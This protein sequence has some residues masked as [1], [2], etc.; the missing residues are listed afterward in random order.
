MK[1]SD[2]LATKIKALY[3]SGV[4][5]KVLAI[6]FDIPIGSIQTLINRKPCKRG[7]PPKVRDY[8]IWFTGKTMI[9]RRKDDD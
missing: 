4:S 2:E 7:R 6:D 8:E 5:Y 9:G 1:Y 3:K